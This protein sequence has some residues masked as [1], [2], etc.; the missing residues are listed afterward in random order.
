MSLQPGKYF[1]RA[2]PES[3]QFGKATTGTEQIAITFRILDGVTNG[4]ETGDEIALLGALGNERS[5]EITAKALR[6]CGYEEPEDFGHDPVCIAR[7]V[8]ELDVQ[9][10][11]FQ[12]KVGLRVKWINT[13]RRFAFKQALDAGSKASA[14]SRLK[15]FAIRDAQANGAQ[16]SAPARVVD[17]IP[18]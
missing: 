6:A 2:I 3:V 1:A 8:V 9:A 18:F 12:G 13:P 7:N 5:L 17:D 15:G 4:V 10:D 16:P 11:M 14:L